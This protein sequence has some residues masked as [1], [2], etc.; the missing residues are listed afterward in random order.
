MI[1]GPNHAGQV[2]SLCLWALL[3]S[4]LGSEA[5]S[6]LRWQEAA[7]SL[8]SAHIFSVNNPMPGGVGGVPY[9]VAPAQVL[10]KA[11]IG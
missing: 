3:S 7:S 11:L 9:T 4:V 6:P 1:Q 5:V 2:V 10:G 8:A